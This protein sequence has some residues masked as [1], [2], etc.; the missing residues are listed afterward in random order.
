MDHEYYK[1]SEPFPTR[2]FRSA[3]GA[4]QDDGWYLVHAAYGIRA[5]A[6]PEP[7]GRVERCCQ[8]WLRFLSG[9]EMHCLRLSGKLSVGSENE[10]KRDGT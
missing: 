8:H 1:A 10:M 9:N 4:F 2:S 5:E 6:L 7:D 3:S